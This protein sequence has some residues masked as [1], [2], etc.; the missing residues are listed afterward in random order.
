MALASV[1]PSTLAMDGKRSTINSLANNAYLGQIS[2]TTTT[3]QTGGWLD[4]TG[5][6]GFSIE[7]IQ[8]T[9]MG[10]YRVE[11]SNDDASTKTKVY[12]LDQ[13]N[14]P[15]VAQ[16]NDY[17]INCV[18]GWKYLRV[19]GAPTASN[20]G[21]VDFYVRR[22]DPSVT[23]AVQSGYADYMS[24]QQVLLASANRTSNL[25]KTDFRVKGRGFKAILSITANSGAAGVLS[26]YQKDLQ[27]GLYTLTML[28]SASLTTTGVLF[29]TLYPDVATVANVSAIQGGSEW[30]VDSASITNMTYS[31]TIVP[32]A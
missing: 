4:L 31:L 5:W 10:S 18:E 1:V 16:E 30:A 13:N 21:T 14:N 12:R 29:Y 7:V 19:I 24:R 28:D 20:A 11:V 15:T 22:L 2:G 9:F 6:A 17:V 8:A 27:T 32:L 26:F 25:S 23:P 3:T